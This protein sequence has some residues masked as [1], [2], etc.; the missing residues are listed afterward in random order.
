M[1]QKID[2]DVAIRVIEAFESGSLD[3]LFTETNVHYFDRDGFE[4]IRFGTGLPRDAVWRLLA[5]VRRATGLVVFESAWG[6]VRVR[7]S[8]TA[9]LMQALYEIDTWPRRS[10]FGRSGI[11]ADE[12]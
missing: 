9:Q 6:D 2:K 4:S 3:R 5:S 10:L 7:V 8:L 11:P 12:E 1:T